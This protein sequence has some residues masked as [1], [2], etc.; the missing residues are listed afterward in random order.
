MKI[1]GRLV[2]LVVYSDRINLFPEIHH[3]FRSLSVGGALTS[4]TLPGQGSDLVDPTETTESGERKSVTGDPPQ[5]KRSQL[6]NHSKAD[7]FHS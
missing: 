2:N 1:T 4:A 3:N 6:G 5:I 7:S